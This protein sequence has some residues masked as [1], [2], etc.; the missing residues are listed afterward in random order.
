MRFFFPNQ[1]K[2]AVGLVNKILEK[3][4]ED[5]MSINDSRC[6]ACD[7]AAFLTRVSGGVQQKFLKLT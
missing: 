5:K 3:L 1:Q 6:Q 7:N 4:E 2:Y